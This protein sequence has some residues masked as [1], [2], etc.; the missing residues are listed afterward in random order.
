MSDNKILSDFLFGRKRF[1]RINN[2]KN[3]RVR[4]T[5]VISTEVGKNRHIKHSR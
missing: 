1:T 3:T 4:Y 5:Q 2:R